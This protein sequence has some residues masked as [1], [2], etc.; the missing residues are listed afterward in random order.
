MSFRLL[1]QDRRNRAAFGARLGTARMQTATTRRI[2]RTWHLAL[3][4][5]ALASRFDRAIRH[6]RCGEQCLRIRVQWVGIQGRLGC[7]LD[8]LAKVHDGNPIAQMPDHS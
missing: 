1:S 7:D 8:D 2:E 6:W 3:Q 4:K 5:R